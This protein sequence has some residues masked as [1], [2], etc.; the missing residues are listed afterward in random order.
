VIFLRVSTAA[1]GEKAA[2]LRV[3]HTK[4]ERMAARVE[5]GYK[6]VNQKILVKTALK[7][8][9]FTPPILLAHKALFQ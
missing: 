9:R 1:W 8:L 6:H 3:I 7:N 5:C 4:P 2:R